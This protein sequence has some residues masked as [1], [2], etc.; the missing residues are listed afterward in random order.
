VWGGLVGAS[1]GATA[2]LIDSSC[3]EDGSGAVFETALW[4]GA[5]GA[6]LGIARSSGVEFLAAPKILADV[7]F[8]ETDAWVRC[9]LAEAGTPLRRS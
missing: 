7:T 2:C 5:M 1:A 9:H 3:R 6:M 4:F 8:E